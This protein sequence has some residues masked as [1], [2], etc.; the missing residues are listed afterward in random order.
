M[1]MSANAS[2]DFEGEETSEGTI[3]NILVFS[4][5]YIVRTGLNGSHPVC[6]SIITNQI[7]TVIDVLPMRK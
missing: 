3:G 1:T 6:K 7:L 5:S 2:N 4:M